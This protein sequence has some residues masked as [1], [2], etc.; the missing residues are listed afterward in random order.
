LG[1]AGIHFGVRFALGA[2][3]RFYDGEGR[4]WDVSGWASAHPSP[5]IASDWHEWGS[6]DAGRGWRLGAL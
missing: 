2:A 5:P 4:V 6:R 3:Y 1:G